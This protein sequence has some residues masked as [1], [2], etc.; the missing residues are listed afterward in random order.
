[1]DRRIALSREWDGL[2]ASVRE[3]GRARGIPELAGF[4]QPPKAALLA[5]AGGEGA[6]VVVNISRS[7]CDALLIADGRVRSLPLPGVTADG[8]ETRAV[9]YLVALSTLEQAGWELQAALAE[10]EAG[11]RSPEV[12]FRVS[13]ARAALSAARTGAEEELAVLTAWL[14]DEICGPVLDAL[15]HTGEPVGAAPLPRLWW[16]PTGLLNLLPLHAAGHHG[17]PVGDRPR[18]VLDRVVSSYTPTVR[19]LLAARSRPGHGG[20]GAG[21]MLF[22]A[23]EPAGL[24]VLESIA[25]DRAALA[26]RFGERLTRLEGPDATATAV[27]TALRDHRWVHFSTHAGQDLDDPGLGAIALRDAALTV[28]D[29]A[30]GSYDGELAFLSAC[31]TAVGGIDLAN[32]A[33]TLCAALHVAGFRHVIGTL[34]SVQ[35]R[36]AAA[37]TREFYAAAAGDAEEAGNTATDA[38][39]A[40]VPVS[41]PDPVPDFDASAAARCLHRAV[42]ALREHRPGQLTA[43]VPFIHIGP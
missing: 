26:G 37:V 19:A 18:T 25:D 31:Q 13:G 22:V 16:C 21:R 15:G 4:L 39:S 20:G 12:F 9:A 3:L 41:A 23:P 14:W 38:V 5:E 27:L 42:R 2:V 33:I 6:V 43:W 7:R 35:D 10:F 29:L 36:A 40:P 32:E 34:W 8:V 11:G 30:A 24:P 28:H 17:E 1:M